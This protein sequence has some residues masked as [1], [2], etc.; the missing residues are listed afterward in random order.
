MGGITRRRLL[1]SGA[2][3][4]LGLPFL[5][6]FARGADAPPL[7]LVILWTP[8]DAEWPDQYGPRLG[9][10]IAGRSTAGELFRPGQRLRR[11]DDRKH[12]FRLTH[13]LRPREQ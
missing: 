13:G 5:G 10:R 7:R 3:A 11:V 9:G 1:G 12:A 8:N 4:A 2:A 6:S